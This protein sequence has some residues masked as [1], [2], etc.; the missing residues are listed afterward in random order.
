MQRRSHD[1][2][3]IGAGMVGATAACLLARTGLSVALIEAREPPAFRADAEVGLRV[4]AISPGS[5][6]ILAEAG[7]WRLIAQNRHCPYRR[8]R[9]EDRN[10]RAVL[11]FNSG[12]F[13]LERLGT[14]VE[15]EL[16]HWAL[17]QCLQSL[18]GVEL[19]CPAQIEAF[20]L[21]SDQPGVCLA[22]GRE[23]RA[24]L[25]VAS[26]GA[27]SAVRRALGIDLRYW[28]YGQ[29]GIVAVVRTAIANS[30]L[31]W[32]RFVRG[33]TLAF[34]PLADGASSIVWSCPDVEARRLL[35][36]DD[37]LFCTELEA[38]AGAGT[39]SSSR[40][41]AVFGSVLGCGPRGSFPLFMQL[42]DT[43]AVRR[44]VLIGDAA[45]VIHPLAGQGA[46]LGLADAAALAETLIGARRAGDEVGN[47]KALQQFARWRRSEA[48]LMAQ[49]ID[50]IRSLFMPDALG[51]IRRLGLG[52]VSGSW[53]LKD[54]FVRRA[55]GRHGNAPALARGV[56]L[57]ELMLEKEEKSPSRVT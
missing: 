27:D 9:V 26:D 7:A 40:M 43:S 55:A 48:E 21:D 28:S 25:L 52:L 24:R 11:E 31:A 4:S 34:L 3:I 38:A 50:G 35:G 15:N 12:E 20:D 6:A 2:L 53:M 42:T 57:T 49:G 44:A 29:Q 46:N 23:V 5:Q 47:E 45:H 36:L 18:A 13:G 32:Q 14:I 19:L 22:G 39:D 1:V 30:G 16:L 37:Q 33:G 54:A 8:M 10:A 51:P 17:W 56:C 41:S